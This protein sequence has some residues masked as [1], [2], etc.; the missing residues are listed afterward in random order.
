MSVALMA[1]V[2]VMGIGFKNCGPI[3]SDAPTT[4]EEAALTNDSV[5]FVVVT[6]NNGAKV[7]FVAKAPAPK[8]TLAADGFGNPMG[9]AQGPSGSGYDKVEV[10]TK[11]GTIITFVQSN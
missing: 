6:L 4:M 3:Q 2:A 7:K 1:L 9:L 8:N 10:V 11:D 5:E